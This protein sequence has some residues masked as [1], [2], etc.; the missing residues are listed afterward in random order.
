MLHAIGGELQDVS[1]ADGLGY[2]AVHPSACLT[3]E[4]YKK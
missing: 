3:P 2:D 1:K 4:R